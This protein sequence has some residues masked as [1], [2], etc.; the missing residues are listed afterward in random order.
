MIALRLIGPA[1]CLARQPG[2]ADWIG[3]RVVQKK[4]DFV[5][6][7]EKHVVDRKS[8]LQTYRVEQVNGHWLWLCAGGLAGWA[9]ADQVLPVEQAIAYYTDYIRDHPD[10]PYGYSMCAKFLL[11][12]KKDLA[13]ALKDYNEAIRLDPSI[14]A[15]HA[16]RGN[17]WTARK[18]YDKAIADYNEALWSIPP[19]P[20]ATAAAASPACQEGIRQGHRRLLRGD[21]SLSPARPRLCKPGQ[22]ISREKGILQGH[23]RLHR[24]DSS[25]TRKWHGRGQRPRSRVVWQEGF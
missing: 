24:G 22:R 1:N 8:T 23:R 6:R 21:S 7:V 12:E 5:L 9:R 11:D 25:G 2:D 3:K 17:V 19:S 13:A 18:E 16:N 14:D 4:R 10:D 15:V 20:S